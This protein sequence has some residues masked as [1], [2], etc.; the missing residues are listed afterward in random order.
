MSKKI[1]VIINVLVLIL[2]INFI[3]TL[4]KSNKREYPTADNIE[5]Y[6]YNEQYDVHKFR[7]THGGATLGFGYGVAIFKKGYDV[8]NI[9]YY[10][11]DYIV[12][13]SNTPID[14]SVDDKITVRYSKYVNT[15]IFIKRDVEDI[16]IEYV[17]GTN[18]I[19]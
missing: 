1:F 17:E 16:N 18:S 2:F 7:Q 9:D 19:W 6:S 3:C 5:I 10:E 14:V 12:W 15:H 13:L 11:G 8:K 4:N